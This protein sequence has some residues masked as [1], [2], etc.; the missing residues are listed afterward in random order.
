MMKKALY[1]PLLAL[2]LATL[3]LVAG[4]QAANSGTN[5]TYQYQS[6]GIYGCNQTGAA[7]SSVGQFSA[8]G[9]YVPVADATVE[10]NT[11]YL[12][13]LFCSLRPLV[14]ALSQSATAGLTSKILTA[15]NTGNNGGPQFS[16][17]SDIEDRQAATSKFTQVIQSGILST[18]NPALQSTTQ[19][20]LVQQFA[21]S[22]QQANSVLSC[23]YSGDLNALLSGNTF[24][25]AGLQALQ[26]PA[27][28]PIGAY[29]LASNLVDGYVGNAVQ[30]NVALRQ[31]GSGMYP[32]TTT[33][34]F[35]NVNIVTPGA[36]VLA[37]AN[38]ALGSGFLKTE[39][40]QDIGQMVNALFA[41]IGAN[42]V[43]SPQGLAGITQSLAGQ[44]SYMS[45][46]VSAASANAS[47]SAINTAVTALNSALAAVTSYQSA[48]TTI[49]NSYVGAVQSLRAT[50]NLCWNQLIS[51]ICATNTLQVSNGGPTCKESQSPAIT[52]T[53]A[54]STEFSDA[55]VAASITP[56][57]QSAAANL[58][59]A[60][61]EF[62]SL[63]TL[64]ASVSNSTSQDVQSLAIQQLDQL[65]AS[66]AF[67]TSAS[68]SAAQASAQQVGN[69]MSTLESAT[70]KNWEGLPPNGPTDAYG[71]A[72]PVSWDGTVSASTVGWCDYTDP[73][74]LAAW[75]AQW[76]K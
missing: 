68:I 10:L 22:T 65:T 46:V 60:Q 57:A 53:I 51:N 29:S 49:S 71:N 48:L 19:N 5:Q 36:M 27:C 58:P 55:V 35:Q 42:A 20:A 37:Q 39:N 21:V 33:D 69:N 4:A 56:Q 44:P 45:Q 73:K 59:Q 28:N 7:A 40:A 23:P 14:S 9:V 43:S 62:N 76:S 6:D 67:P 1:I 47:A 12:V 61:A 70:V 41:G 75:E 16:Q 50:E 52:L 64:A 74:T 32:I 54:T 25:W 8:N 17:N 72:V 24:D 31:Q 63:S 11:G 2:I 66:N 3:P 18:L 13:Y 38:Q 34:S 26:N 15:V 30:D